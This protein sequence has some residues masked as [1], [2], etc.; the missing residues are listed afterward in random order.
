[1]IES[2]KPRFLEL[3]NSLF[4]AHN[5]TVWDG[6]IAGY[7]M[8]LSKMSLMQFERCVEKAVEKLQHAERGVS[9]IPTVGELWDISRGIRNYERPVTTDDSKWLG[10]DWDTAANLILL[11]YFDRQKDHG[12]MARYAPDSPFSDKS[13]HV[14]VGPLTKE[15]TAVMVKWKNAWARDMRED[16]QLYDGKL[17]GKMAWADCMALAEKELDSLIAKAEAA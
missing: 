12:R 13:H 15:R 9:K 5:R 17:D 16:R 2:E 6:A 14:V 8:G 10:D 11:G 3:M 4:G 1:M 7:W